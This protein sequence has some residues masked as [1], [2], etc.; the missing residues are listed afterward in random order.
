MHLLG[1]YTELQSSLFPPDEI[2]FIGRFEN[3]E[4]DFHYICEKIGLSNI[5]LPHENITRHKHYI[6]YYDDE[7][8]GI[9]AEIY[10]KDIKFFNY[11]FGQNHLNRKYSFFQGRFR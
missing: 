8:R 7:T 3:L 5:K 2:D 10:V 6:K 4:E 9:V 1:I 11:K